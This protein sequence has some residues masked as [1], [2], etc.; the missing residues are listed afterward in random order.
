MLKSLLR[1]A[2]RLSILSVIGIFLI[3]LPEAWPTV[4]GDIGAPLLRGFGICFLG[5]VAGDFGLRIL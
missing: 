1:G 4:F 5:L 2:F 3:A